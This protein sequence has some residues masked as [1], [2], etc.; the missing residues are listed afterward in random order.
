MPSNLTYKLTPAGR[1]EAASGSRKLGA[2]VGKL[3]HAAGDGATF[4]DIWKAV[5]QATEARLRDVLQKLA[6][7][8]LVEAVYTDLTA[9]DL[10]IT[11]YFSRPVVEPTL[12]QR[13]DAERH[14]IRGMRALKDAG[15]FVK[16]VNRPGKR[17][18]PRHGGKHVV[19][20]IDGD[21]QNTMIVARA[22]LVAGFDTRS[23]AR[24]K[25]IIAALNRQPP[26][27]VIVMDAALPDVIGLELLGR[28]C[29]HPVYKDVPVIV[30]ASRVGHDDVMAALAYGARGY[31]SKPFRPEVMLETVRAVLG[32]L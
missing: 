13:R 4:E 16:I 1:T 22:L 5:P 24:R 7:R 26:A 25:D 12:I 31:L 20:I 14:T 3:L 32:L 19:L 11:R 10:D 2:T 28:L 9:S 30:M 18:P 23:A 21:E 29:Q 27:D 8:G 6:A 17:I 15:Y